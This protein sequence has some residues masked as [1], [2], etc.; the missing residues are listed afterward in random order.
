[1][2]VVL[3]LLVAS[4]SRADAA[5]YY[6]GGGKGVRLALRVVDRQIVWS[7][8][9]VEGQCYGSRRGYFHTSDFSEGLF[10]QAQIGRRGAFST[11]SGS[12]NLGHKGNEEISSSNISGRIGPRRL[13]GKVL[14]YSWFTFHEPSGQHFHGRCWGASGPRPPKHLTPVKITAL[15]RPEPPGIDFY[16]SPPKG[17]L[18]TYFEV[19]GRRI[20]RAE[21]AAVHLCVSRRGRHYRENLLSAFRIPIRIR[22]SGAF[23]V[24]EPPDEIKALEVLK[25]TVGPGRIVGSYGYYYGFEGDGTRCRTGSLEPR[26]DRSWALPFVAPLR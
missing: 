19:M 22:P 13:S 4:T 7:K 26:S 6:V 8:V 5:A 1:M 16:Y 18:T 10:G 17:G 14:Y 15:R 24:Y 20:V 9:R 2:V 12:R 21:V 23:R 3:G 11:H 25:G